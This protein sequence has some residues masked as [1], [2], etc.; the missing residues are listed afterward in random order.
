[1]RTLRE[2]AT[3]RVDEVSQ[4]LGP[5]DDRHTAIERWERHL[6]AH[7]L[8]PDDILEAMPEISRHNEPQESPQEYRCSCVAMTRITDRDALRHEEPF[9][10]R[11]AIRCDG[12]AC[13]VVLPS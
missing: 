13:K 8:V 11:L 6:I 9:E 3:K 12:R 4:D 10:M 2:F 7:G 1:M 5:P